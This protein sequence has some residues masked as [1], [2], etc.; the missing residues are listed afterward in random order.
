MEVKI[1]IDND[2]VIFS[3]NG[4]EEAKAIEEAKAKHEANVFHEN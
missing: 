3:K 4:K 1:T 2:K